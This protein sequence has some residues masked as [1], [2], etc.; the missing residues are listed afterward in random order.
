MNKLRRTMMYVPGNNPGKLLSAGIYG[1]DTVIFDLEDAVAV[2][3][4]DAARYLVAN[5]V[6]EIEYPCE[7]AVRINHISTPFGYDDLECILAA[8]PDMIRL[9]K[10]EYA[11]DIKEIADIIDKAEAKHGFPQ[12]SIKMMA[13]IESAQGLVNA[14]EIAKASPRMAAIAIGGE[15]FIADLNTSRSRE[16]TE[17][18]YARSQIVVAARVAKIQAIDSVSTLLNDDEAFIQE[19]KMIK[20]LGFDGK[21]CVHPRQVEL[22]H[23]VYTPTE[24]EVAQA[25]RILAG[26][27]EAL[28]R[29]SGVIAVDGKMVDGPII[30]RAERTIAYAAVVGMI[31]GDEGND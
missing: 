28:A 18:F 21:S 8:K 22:I 25:H 10:A 1:A 23:K 6:R 16:G 17:L 24:K 29:K 9:P 19:V 15:D 13:S 5:A 26:I 31:K 4:K 7:V 20:Q 14:C 2:T 11:D 30:T 3:E 12:G 27:K